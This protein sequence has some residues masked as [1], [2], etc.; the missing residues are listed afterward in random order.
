MGISVVPAKD[1]AARSRKY[2]IMYVFKPSK[3]AQ[4]DNMLRTLRFLFGS[5]LFFSPSN[6]RTHDITLISSHN[7][8][9]TERVCVS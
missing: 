4:S 7:R 6:K 8:S 9:M 2:Y 5:N 3:D 1:G